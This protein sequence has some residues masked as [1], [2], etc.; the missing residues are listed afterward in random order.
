MSLLN[1]LNVHDALRV[2]AAPVVKVD[3]QTASPPPIEPPKQ[4]P[5]DE[6]ARS[7]RR[8]R[9]R[10]QR[11]STVTY[12]RRSGLNRRARVDDEAQEESAL[13]MAINLR[14]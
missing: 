9:D 3:A 7:D 4:A 14:V 13:G 12:E 1:P 2:T 5:R 8:D 6:K 11:K 10:R